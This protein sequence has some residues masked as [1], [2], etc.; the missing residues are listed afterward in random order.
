MSKAYADLRLKQK[1]FVRRQVEAGLYNSAADVIEDA[2]QRLSES[3]DAKIEAIKAALAPG[4][5]EADAGVYFEGGAAEII[6]AAHK[7]LAQAE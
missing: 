1:G 2:L 4:L 3:D 6:E 7:R 5:A